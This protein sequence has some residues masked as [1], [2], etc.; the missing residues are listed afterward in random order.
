[1]DHLGLCLLLLLQVLCQQLLVL[2]CA[3]FADFF[4]ENLLEVFEE[5]VSES[6]STVALL[7]WEALFVDL[8]SITSEAFW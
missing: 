7:A 2:T 3:I 1:M 8:L 6:S 4:S 5:F